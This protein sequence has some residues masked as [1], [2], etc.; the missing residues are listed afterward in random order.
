[1]STRNIVASLLVSV[2]LA[3]VYLLGNP[4]EDFC[5]GAGACADSARVP[6]VVGMKMSKAYRVL[7]ERG[8][9]CAIRDE[10]GDTGG[11]VRR[12]VAQKEKPG[13]E[14]PEGDIVRLIVSKPY[15]QGERF[16]RDH[17][18]GLLPPN[19]IDQRDTQK[20]EESPERRFE[21]W[22]SHP[23]RTMRASSYLTPLQ[24]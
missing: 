16:P 14:H 3:G 19:C 13:Q 4:G 24:T 12:V 23:V 6:D 5:D 11:E 1:M 20:Q 21:K 18:K 8:F 10:R 9:G 2:L 7:G 15:P 17:G 22:E